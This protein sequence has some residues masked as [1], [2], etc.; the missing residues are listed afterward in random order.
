[1]R[2]LIRSVIESELGIIEALPAEVAN[3]VREVYAEFMPVY[4]EIIRIRD[5]HPADWQPRKVVPDP[6]VVED[7]LHFTSDYQDLARSFRR[8]NRQVKY[9]LTIDRQADPHRFERCVQ[10]IISGGRGPS[11]M[12]SLVDL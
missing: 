11:L 3:R 5:D 8:I 10:D 6:D 4:I 9:L 12:D 2:Q 7:M 1:M